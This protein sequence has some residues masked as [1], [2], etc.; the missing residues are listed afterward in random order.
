[1]MTGTKDRAALADGLGSSPMCPSDSR[2]S[3]EVAHRLAPT[4]I[5]PSD[6]MAQ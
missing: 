2:A 6:R 5:G 3:R 4:R 1:M